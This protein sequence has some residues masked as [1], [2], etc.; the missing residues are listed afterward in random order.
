[1][2]HLRP[3]FQFDCEKYIYHIVYDPFAAV[4]PILLSVSTSN[5]EYP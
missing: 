2:S 4:K 1:M 5:L 3:H